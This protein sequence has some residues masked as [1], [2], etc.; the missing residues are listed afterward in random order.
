M[1]MQRE[2]AETV[3]LQALGWLAGNADLWPVFL[4]A[5][6]ASEADLRA[7]AAEA[8]LLGVVLDFV[9]MDAAWV[10]A[11]CDAH[12]HAYDVPMRARAA[13]PGGQEMH[14]T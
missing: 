8:D 4:G 7:R 10:V 5:T 1:S 14:W 11:F 9:M 6:G 13:L 3:A 12:G 2:T